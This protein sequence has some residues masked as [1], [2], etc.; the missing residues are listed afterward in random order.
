MIIVAIFLG[1]VFACL[2][3][4]HAYWACGGTWAA[5]VALPKQ[6]NGRLLFQP[7]ISACVL[8]AL[9]LAA[10]AYLCLAHVGLVPFAVVAGWTKPGLFGIGG[11]FALRTLGD[12]KYVGFFRQVRTTDFAHMDRIL[13]TPLCFALSGLL[14]WL[15]W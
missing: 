11:I 14:A 1:I 15:A 5:G 10:F 2:A 8:V 4:L 7:G 12:F 13:Y 6:T 3:L 9:G